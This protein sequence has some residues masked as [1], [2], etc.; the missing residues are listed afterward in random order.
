VY[1]AVRQAKREEQMGVVEELWGIM[2]E[3]KF[4]YP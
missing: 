4:V 3:R 1:F 2:G